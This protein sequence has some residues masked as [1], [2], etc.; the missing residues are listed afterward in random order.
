MKFKKTIYIILTTLLF[1][2]ISYGLHA[3]IELIILK[4]NTN[5]T[6]YTHFGGSCALHPIISYGLLAL[7]LVTGLWI[8]PKWWKWVYIIRFKFLLQHYDII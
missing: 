3:I 5:I 4:S 8:G 7:G 1:V 6:W 2:I